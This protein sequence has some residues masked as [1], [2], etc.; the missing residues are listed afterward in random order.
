MAGEGYEVEG[1]EGQVVQG[2]ADGSRTPMRWPPTVFAKAASSSFA[3]AA[4]SCLCYGSS[5]VHSLC[6]IHS[7]DHLRHA[8]YHPPPTD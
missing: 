2:R 7:P 5:Y 6:P 3:M 8:A 1:R 4:P